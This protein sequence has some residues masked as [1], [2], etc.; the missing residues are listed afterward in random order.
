MKNN[1]P[2]NL[3]L[4]NEI[5]ENI[6]AHVPARV[7]EDMLSRDKEYRTW[8]ERHSEAVEQGRMYATLDYARKMEHRKEFLLSEYAIATAKEAV[9]TFQ[10]DR[11]LPKEE[12]NEYAIL[13]GRTLCAY[14]ALESLLVDLK[15]FYHKAGIQEYNRMP[16]EIDAA[17]ESIK[18]WFKFGQD[19][20]SDCKKMLDDE[21]DK[22]YKFIKE[23]FDETWVNMNKRMKELEAEKIAKAE[24]EAKAKAKAEQEA[25]EMAKK[26][27]ATKKATAKKATTKKSTSKKKTA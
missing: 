10:L 24:A 2:S 12:R 5:V 22:V 7:L 6:K 1:I 8:K 3:H 23:S 9:R 18:K 17:V 13:L 20:E 25:K 15:A 16:K 21:F 14:D 26:K 27:P 19:L 11:W 4:L